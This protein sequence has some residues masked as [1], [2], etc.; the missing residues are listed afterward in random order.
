MDSAPEIFRILLVEDNAG[1]ARLI[2]E[3]L[4]E[5]Q[6]TPFKLTR[7]VGTLAAGLDVIDLGEADLVLLDLT[8]P[9]SSGIETF[10]K[11]HAHAPQMPIIVLSGLDDEELAVRTVHEGAQ[12]YLVKGR[13]DS[14][15]LLRSMRYAVERS[16]V[17]QALASERDLLQTLLDNVPDR[18]YFKD[19]ESRFIRV[20]P[21]M[22]ELFA[23]KGVKSYEDILGKSD[24]DFFSKEA[25]QK[26]FAEE[27]EVIRSGQPI[28]GQIEKKKISDGNFGWEITTK[29]PLRDRKGEIRGTA[30]I[31]R[32][33]TELKQMEE[34][35]SAERNLLRS[36]IDNLPDPIYMK[37]V[38]GRYVVDNA[39][40]TEFLGVKSQNEIIGKT[41]FDFF[42][43]E[44]AEQ[45][46]AADAAI[47][48]SRAPL[49]NHE[50]IATDSRGNRRWLLTTKVPL[51]G[52]SG[53]VLGLVCVGRDIT[54]QKEAEQK[55]LQ[56]NI[57]L[58]AAVKDLQAAHEELRSVQIQ[59]IEAEKL[60]SIGRLA[61]G[62]AHEVKNPL[63]I[64]TMGIDYLSQ[65]NFGGDSNVPPILKEMMEAVKR[66]DGVIR[67]LLDFSAPQ[68][69]EV[70]DEDLNLVIEQALIL[71]RGEMS[72]PK[73]Q[74]VKELQ[75]DLPP[76]KIDRSKMGQVFVNVLT[77]AIH[78]MPEGGTLTVRSFSKQLTGVGANVGDVR[79]ES[80]RVGE[81]I[82]VAEVDDTGHGVPDDKLNKVFDPFFTTKP[83]GKGTGL[84]L[85]V[86]RSIVDLHRGI[87]EIRNRPE[88][89]AR[90]SVMFK[91]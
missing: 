7:S 12:D 15:L 69:L 49:L 60:K 24:F 52:E 48:E 6:K 40:H 64:I 45:F 37:D 79:S 91:V 50:E 31:S 56:A 84:G 73:I 14:Q 55:L 44:V 72:G 81:T 61:A 25:A 58:S 21:A 22:V 78:A 54:E 33:I 16:H 11:A 5:A 27:M 89:G 19:R 1:D 41:V 68:R 39:A 70:D 2:K 90:V 74:V 85:S 51:R 8:L 77:N 67:G 9:D 32:D 53:Q 47:M 46:H 80:F 82:V 57:S 34:A 86:T 62:V 76:L 29:V 28:I 23:P 63:A 4:A 59:L 75:P 10:T 43:P 42:P 65:Q 88:G 71:V 13:V 30:G 20:N 3:M 26:K 38:S 35:L 83:T 17:E 36:V 87:I 18:V 66:A